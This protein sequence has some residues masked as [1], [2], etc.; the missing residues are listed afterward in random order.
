MSRSSGISRG[1]GVSFGKHLDQLL[2]WNEGIFEFSRCRVLHIVNGLTERQRGRECEVLHKRVIKKIGMTGVGIDGILLACQLSILGRR[3]LLRY[4]DIPV[5]LSK[6]RRRDD[7][8]AGTGTIS[9]RGGWVA[10]QPSKGEGVLCRPL[11]SC[12]EACGMEGEGVKISPIVGV[13]GD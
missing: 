7:E 13:L 3:S 12:F 6:S 10:G 8:L 11:I 4:E 5:W 1:G 9:R 2:C